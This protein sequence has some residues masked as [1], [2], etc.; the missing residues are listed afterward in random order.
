MATAGPR[1]PR[2]WE[3]G[4][5]LVWRRSRLPRQPASFSISLEDPG[6]GPRTGKSIL[7]H[8]DLA[9]KRWGM[10]MGP[11]KSRRERGGGFR[12]RC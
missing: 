6:D 7:H 10:P 2:G 3:D 8:L 9:M 1:S 4:R 12:R 5:F 11:L